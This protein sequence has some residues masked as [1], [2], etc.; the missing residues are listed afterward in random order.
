MSWLEPLANGTGYALRVAALDGSRWS[1]VQDV[2][3]GRDFFVNWADSPSVL[4]LGERRLVAH[5]LQRT[6]SATYAYGVRLALSRDGGRTWSASVTPHSDTS[7]TE[8]GFVS[9]WRTPRGD[10]FEAVWLDGRK[11]ARAGDRSANEMTLATAGFALDGSVT[12]AERIIDGRVCDCCQTSAAMTSSGP[13]IAY[14]DRSAGEIRD[15][16]IVRRV[17]DAWTEPVPVHRDGWKISACPV[18]GPSVTARGDRVAVAWFTSANDV[19]TVKVAFS[20][21]AGATFAAPIRV[22]GGQPAGRV[23]VELMPDGAALVSW[24]ERTGGD[25]AAVRVRRVDPNGRTGS[26]ITIAASSAARASGFPRMVIAHGD[27]IFAW[28]VPG[29]PSQIKLAKLKVR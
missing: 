26:P 15:I 13:V 4:S 12:S 27:A 6:G 19:P 2:R 1:D 20:R 29:R 24:V 28:T 25:A 14:R 21:D 3:S 22:D 17:E 16:G 11:Y 7:N 5:W 8:H 23:D 18:N 10:G 9:L